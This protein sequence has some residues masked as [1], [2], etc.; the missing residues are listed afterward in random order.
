MPAKTTIPK[1]PSPQTG[2]TVVAPLATVPLPEPVA[3]VVGRKPNLM[4]AFFESL[5]PKKKAI[6]AREEPEDRQNLITA[7]WK[8]VNGKASQWEEKKLFEKKLIKAPGGEA[9]T[10]QDGE[11][12]NDICDTHAEIASRMM[13]H[14]QN[15]DK[16]SKLRITITKGTVSD[17]CAGKRLDGKPLPP[18][19]LKGVRRRWSLRAWLAWFDEH[20]WFDYRANKNQS[21]SRTG[22]NA[23]TK[24]PTGELEEIVK[25]ERLEHERWKIVKEMGG[26]IA[27]P[28]AERHAAGFSRQY[29]DLWKTRNEQ[30]LI[31]TFTIK[32][33]ALGIEAPKIA[34]L[35]DFL[36]VEYQKF[37][38]AVEAG[39][40]KFAAE[41]AEKLKAEL[42]EE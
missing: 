1:K 28:L 19:P 24:M 31:E 40:G 22:D 16:S 38:D 23:P 27:V 13:L 36:T 35:R 11:P 41:L 18:K 17:W 30:S 4:E 26:Y 39:S 14:Y 10:G 12:D 15:P 32:A 33:E 6:L 3:D 9:T 5:S 7:L 25:R 8:Y 42:N 34:V 29:H 2:V 21:A 20:L 37:T